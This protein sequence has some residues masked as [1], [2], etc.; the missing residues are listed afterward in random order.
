M[1]LADLMVAKSGLLEAPEAALDKAIEAA[2]QRADARLLR[3]EIRFRLGRYH[4]ALM[5]AQAAVA[6]APK[7]AAAWKLL[8]RSTARSLGGGAG[9]EAANRAI[10]A[11]GRD[12]VDN[13]DPGPAPA[14]PRHLRA[15]AQTD[16]GNVGAWMREH[17]PGRLAE[18][19][20]E[21]ET[22]LRQKK[23]NEAQRI[24]D[25]A[26]RAYP[27]STFGAFMA[28]T[29]DLAL[30]NADE[31]EK[32]FSEGMEI[33]PRSPTIAAALAR[34]W[35]WKNGAAF[36]AGKLMRLAERDPHFALARYIAARAYVEA[37]DPSQAE[38]AL[39]R[40][41]ELQPD[42][43]VPHQHLVDYY[44]GLDRTA[45]A[46]GICQ[47]GLD[48]F[49]RDVDLQM[50]L[51]QISADLGKTDDAIRVYEDVLSRRPDLDL[52]Q[53]KLAM[54]LAS[55]ED[56]AASQRSMHILR[57]VRNDLPSDPLLLDVLGWVHYR[58][59]DARR[60]REL[61]EAAVK[62]APDEPGLHFHLG[63]VYVQEKKL[64][65]ARAELK[66]AL[67][68]RRPFAERLDALRLL[69]EALTQMS[70]RRMDESP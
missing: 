50:I 39:R 49:P 69:R 8:V 44:F 25:S 53:Y 45:E 64:E 28:G 43:P 20:E 2:P 57:P 18:M 36:A 52:V 15:D 30:G 68:S 55:R 62:G 63:A 37:R 13:L 3:G 65:L 17:W 51:A 47:Q 19:R 42:S 31:A 23:W 34:A 66:A 58:A 7:D 60:A 14:P 10:A 32:R 11:V 9:T 24:V 26:R 33:A 29:F 67:D 54:L 6:S 35:S 1:G 22:Q 61:L 59:H 41:L 21:L 46:L 5:D 27:D 16:R 12:A 38:A 48:R 4:G 56:Q 70:K 40:G